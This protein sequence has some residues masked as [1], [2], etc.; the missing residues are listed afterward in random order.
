MASNLIISCYDY[1]VVLRFLFCRSTE[2]VQ[3]MN[4]VLFK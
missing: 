1:Q 3:V 4:K 2:E